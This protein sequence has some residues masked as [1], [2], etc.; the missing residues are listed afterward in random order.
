MNLLLYRSIEQWK[1]G[2][3]ALVGVGLIAGGPFVDIAAIV[4]VTVGRRL[5]VPSGSQY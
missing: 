2:S 1:E 4:G 3:S 5:L